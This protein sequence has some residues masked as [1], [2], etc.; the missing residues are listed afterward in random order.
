[1]KRRSLV[2]SALFIPAT[3]LG[4]NGGVPASDRV[5]VACIGTGWQG[6]N[7]VKS[8]LAEPGAQVRALCDIDKTHLAEAQAA[9]PDAKTYHEMDEVFARADIDAVVLSLPDHW[10]GVA[11]TRA[12]AAGKDVYGEKPL[13]QNW[14]EGRAIVDAVVRYGRIWQTG[15]WQR[16]LSSFRFACELVRNG[17]IGKVK[18][19]EVGLPGGH[20]DFDGLGHRNRPEPPPVSL[21]YERWLG[22][23]PAAPYSP[24]RVHKTWRWNFDYGGG[25]LLD[26]VGH[27]VDIAHWGLGMDDSGPEAVSGTGEFDRQ[28]PVWDTP[29]K[30]RVEARYAGGV[31]MWISGGY[32]DVRRGTKFIGDEGWVW[33]DRSGIDAEPRGLLSS[34]IRGN[35]VHLYDSPGHFRNFID[36][37]RSRRETACPASTALRSATPAYLGL[38]AIVTGRT[39]RWDPA[40]QRIVG[41][42]EAER[43]LSR[44]MRSPWHL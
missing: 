2:R 7:N 16:S 29:S 36:C 33:V 5:N 41:D 12:L 35:E 13:A 30:F 39:I 42:A 19:V 1:M 25:M 10:H 15:S 3:A 34:R 43:R 37:V 14:A 40:R 28:H 23:A 22:P 27:H 24:A 20:P 26:W 18:R 32:D 17:R 31:S 44:P 9:A 6:M 8:F 11:S 4:L 38:I 21:D